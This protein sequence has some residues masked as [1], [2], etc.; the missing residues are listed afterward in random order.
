MKRYTAEEV[1]EQKISF[2]PMTEDQFNRLKAHFQKKFPDSYG[3][4]LKYSKNWHYR[5]YNCFRSD[6]LGKATGSYVA[7]NM[8]ARYKSTKEISYDQF[9]FNTKAEKVAWRD[10]PTS[11]VTEAQKAATQ[12]FF[13]TA[14]LPKG[15][16]GVVHPAEMRIPDLSN[17]STGFREYLEEQRNN[18]FTVSHKIGESNFTRKDFSTIDWNKINRV[19][20][21]RLLKPTFPRSDRR[22]GCIFPPGGFSPHNLP[23]ALQ[24]SHTSDAMDSFELFTRQHN[25]TDYKVPGTPIPYNPELILYRKLGTYQFVMECTLKELSRP[26]ELVSKGYYTLNGRL[27][28]KVEYK[29]SDFGLCTY[30]CFED[31][32]KLNKKDMNKRIIGYNLKPNL[33]TNI[34]EAMIKIAGNPLTGTTEGCKFLINSTVWSRFK[35]AGVLDLWFD[36][37]FET[38]EENISMNGQFAIKV[39]DG[40]A[41]HQGSCSGGEDITEFVKQLVNI[42]THP[43]EINNGTIG[44]RKVE[45]ESVTFKSTGCE[46][47]KI[48]RLSDWVELSKKLK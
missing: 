19:W 28:I 47:N 6:D 22:N 43:I 13:D 39:K 10:D 34:L 32:L 24:S 25:M 2:K 14:I 42:F 36:P 44:G 29:N 33:K 38:Q 37:V 40:R 41:Y 21:E 18:E 4:N 11:P 48:T 8:D 16:V 1:R 20:S 46:K 7:D 27:L 12:L 17:F 35:E 5:F 45:I 15:S 31:D 30:Y 3:K 23:P 9:N 26:L